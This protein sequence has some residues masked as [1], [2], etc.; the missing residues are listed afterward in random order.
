MKKLFFVLFMI[1][2]LPT[3]AQPDLTV[4]L[5]GNTANITVKE[6][7]NEALMTQKQ[8]LDC[9]E[10]TPSEEK[11]TELR[12]SFQLQVKEQSLNYT[13]TEIR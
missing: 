13:Q 11:W 12:F 4:Y 3:F 7:A 6:K 1:A 5:C 8:I 10:L 2:C 9:L